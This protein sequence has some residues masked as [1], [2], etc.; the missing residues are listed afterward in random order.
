MKTTIF[1]YI[2]KFFLTAEKRRQEARRK[3]VKDSG[4]VFT[5]EELEEVAKQWKK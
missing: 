4:Y 5:K 3:F 1:N 2:E